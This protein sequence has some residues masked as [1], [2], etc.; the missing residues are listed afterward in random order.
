MVHITYLGQSTFRFTT[1]ESKIVLIDP[2]TAGNPLCPAAEREVREVDLVLISHGHHDH[3]G[4]VF[5]IAE[6]ARPRIVAIVEL[7]KWLGSRGVRN[8]QTMNIGGV[9]ELEGVRITMTAAAHSSSVDA[10]PFAYVGL[11]AGFVVEFSDGSR[12][13]HAGDTAAF[14]GMRLIS[15]VHRPHLALLPIGDHHT[16]G[17]VEAAEAT[18]LLGVEDVVPMHYGVTPGSEDAPTA[19]REALDAAGLGAVRTFV[20]TPG[21]TATWERT[22]GIRA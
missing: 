4:D 11:A 13:Y 17:P 6:A 2:W 3:L 16:M 9:I 8:I 5:A 21:Q 15:T 12:I 18:R 1:P 22:A 7:G 20:M 14:A 19:Y 10:D